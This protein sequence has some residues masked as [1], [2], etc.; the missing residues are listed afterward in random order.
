MWLIRK[1]NFNFPATVE[2]HNINEKLLLKNYILMRLVPKSETEITKFY[3]N[4]R[5]W[6]SK[7]EQHLLVTTIYTTARKDFAE[8]EIV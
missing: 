4:N 7:N 3:S 8:D 2:M 5:I 6:R 1:F